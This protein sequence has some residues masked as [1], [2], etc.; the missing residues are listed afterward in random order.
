M[1]MTLC[2]GQA[3][4]A[5][6]PGGEH[7]REGQDEPKL[8]HLRPLPPAAWRNCAPRSLYRQVWSPLQPRG[9]RPAGPTR[10]EATDLVFTLA[11]RT[12]AVGAHGPCQCPGTRTVSNPVQQV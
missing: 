7:K 8:L 4:G 3:R 10:S 1:V 11:E 6:E 5:R 12:C 2:H 9:G